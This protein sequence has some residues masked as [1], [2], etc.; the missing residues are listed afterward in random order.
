MIIESLRKATLRAYKRKQSRP[1]VVYVEHSHATRAFNIVTES[2]AD[3][4]GYVK[5][6][7]SAIQIK[8]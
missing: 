3:T 4:T 7:D 2:S 5:L 6:F 8:V 1:L